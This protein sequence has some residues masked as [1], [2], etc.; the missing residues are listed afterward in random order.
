MSVEIY[1][2]GWNKQL[3]KTYVV[4]YYCFEMKISLARSFFFIL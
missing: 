2:R 3:V 4:F 1:I